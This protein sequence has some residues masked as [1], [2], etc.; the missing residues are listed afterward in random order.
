MDDYCVEPHCKYRGELATHG[1][2]FHRPTYASTKYIEYVQK[3]AGSALDG[4]KELRKANKQ[5]SNL[6]WIRALEVHFLCDW[7]NH[8]F[9]LDELV[10]YRAVN[11]DL[12]RRLKAKS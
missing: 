12:K 9:M 3:Q 2:C 5:Q 1:H 4:M 10:H 8:T 7:M 11:A 6:A